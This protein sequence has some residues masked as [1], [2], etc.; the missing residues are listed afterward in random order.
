LIQ[1]VSFFLLSFVFFFYSIDACGFIF[2]HVLRWQT[3]RLVNHDPAV[4]DL[5]FL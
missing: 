1:R 2:V 3:A 5:S 4:W